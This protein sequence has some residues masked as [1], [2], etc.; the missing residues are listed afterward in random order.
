VVLSPPPLG[1]RASV[2]SAILSRHSMPRT[3][4]FSVGRLP[5]RDPYREIPRNREWNYMGNQAVITAKVADTAK[6]RPLRIDAK[7]RGISFPASTKVRSSRR[8][9]RGERKMDGCKRC[10]TEEEIDEATTESRPDD[11]RRRRCVRRNVEKVHTCSREGR[12]GARQ[13]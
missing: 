1:T 13:L 6:V 8:L 9:L 4:C 11:E 3:G 10:E 7:P 12:R 5:Y 2:E